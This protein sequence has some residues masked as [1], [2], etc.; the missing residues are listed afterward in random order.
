MRCIAIHGVCGYP[1]VPKTE[2]RD[3]TYRNAVA[4]TVE[5]SCPREPHLPR[6]CGGGRLGFVLPIGSDGS[7][8]LKLLASLKSVV[9]R[10]G[11]LIISPVT[12]ALTPFA[13]AMMK[14]NLL[15]PYTILAMLWS[16]VSYIRWSI[17][18]ALSR[19]V[20]ARRPAAS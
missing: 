9:V 7:Y 15:S 19:A 11:I 20:L 14:C 2:N 8:G 18:T 1:H 5:T 13:S 16:A 12:S 6:S 17:K 3:V 4:T 10:G